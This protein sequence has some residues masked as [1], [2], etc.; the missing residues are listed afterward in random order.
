VGR[1]VSYKA[2]KA[3]YRPFILESK[4]YQERACYRKRGEVWVFKLLPRVVFV[5]SV[6]K[7][8]SYVLGNN[9]NP[10]ILHI[11]FNQKIHYLYLIMSKRCESVARRNINTQTNEFITTKLVGSNALINRNGCPCFRD[12]Q[13][14]LAYAVLSRRAL[15]ILNFQ[16]ESLNDEKKLVVRTHLTVECEARALACLLAFAFAIKTL[17]ILTPRRT[18]S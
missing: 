15:F 10:I 9:I 14:S 8:L 7:K 13:S 2:L 4:N 6:V 1:H 3:I 18:N 5:Y 16:K 11:K 17:T 12:K